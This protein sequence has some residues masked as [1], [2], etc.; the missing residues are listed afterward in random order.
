M[1]V[2]MRLMVVMVLNLGFNMEFLFLLVIFW[3]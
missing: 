2:R 1:W 3:K